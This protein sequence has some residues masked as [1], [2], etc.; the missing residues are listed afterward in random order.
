MLGGGVHPLLRKIA[1]VVAFLTVSNRS[2]R[3]LHAVFMVCLSTSAFPL[4]DQ[5]VELSFHFV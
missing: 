5:F 2:L 1:A 4:V 3:R